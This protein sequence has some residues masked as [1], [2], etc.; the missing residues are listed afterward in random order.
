MDVQVEGA[1]V[2]RL[3]GNKC[4]KGEEYARQEVFFPGRIL[5]TTAKTTNPVA[6]L[7]PVRSRKAIPK[8]KLRECMRVIAKHVVTGPLQL[9]DVVIPDIL[10]LDVDIVACRTLRGNAG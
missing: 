4:K 7:L 1:E 6:P 10:G 3:E 5:T 8:D 9:G 2:I